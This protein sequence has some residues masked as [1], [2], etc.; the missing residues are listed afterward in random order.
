LVSLVRS[1][2]FDQN[3]ASGFS[4]IW[5][6]LKSLQIVSNITFVHPAKLKEKNLTKKLRANYCE[7]IMMKEST[8]MILDE[9]SDGKYFSDPLRH[10]ED[11]EFK[12]KNFLDLFINFSKRSQI[13]ISSIVDVG[14][15][16]GE[17]I[18]RISAGLKQNGFNLAEVK[19]YDISPH[20]KSLSGDENIEF[21]HGDFCNSSDHVDL[22]TLFDVFEHVP[23][24]IEFI[25]LISKRCKMVVFHIPLDDSINNLARNKLRSKLVDPGHLLFMDTTSALNLLTL[26]GLKVLDYKYTFGFL[27][28][29]GHPTI[30][31]KI[32]FPFRYLLSRVNPWLLSKTIGGAN[33]MVIAL[34]ESGMKDFQSDV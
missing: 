12:V 16:S 9:Y 8:A 29:S 19:G 27:A 1:D 18:K 17:N 11:S 13:R 28:P 31:S 33:L 7:Q 21:I 3:S 22:V 26:S 34:T 32:A 5:C 30:I 24:T 20:V 4:K 15:G 14:C 2:Y 6:L 23:N 10:S 25:R